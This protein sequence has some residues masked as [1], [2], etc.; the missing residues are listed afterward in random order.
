MGVTTPTT[1]TGRRPG[2]ILGTRVLRTEDPALLV[3]TAHY[4]ADVDLGDYH[5]DG[6]LHAVFVRSDVA[7]GRLIAVHTD[8]AAAMDGV[9]AIWTAADLDVNP[10]HGFVKVHDD[11]TRP[12]LATDTVRFVGE[13]IAVVLART[14]TAG[15]DA[16]EA[17]WAEIEPLPVLVD[18]EAAL[19]ADAPAIFEPHG[20]NL[21]LQ[22]VDP[23]PLDLEAISDHVVRGRY[24]NQRVAV[25]S[26]ETDG[27]AAAPGR[28]GR[29]VVWPSTQMPHVV[30]DQLAAA[31]ALE[32]DQLHIIT[33]QVGG[34]FGG[35]VG[36]HHEFSVVAAAA[37]RL[38]RPVAWVPTRRED[39]VSMPH[40]RGQ[41]QYVELGCRT[42][43]T[44]T[45][46]RVRLV[47]DAGAYPTIGAFLCG[48]TRRM[49]NATY[50]FGAIDFDVA[51]A[52]TNTT[53]VGAYRGAGRPEATALVERIVDQAATELGI[54]PIE[55]RLRN[56]IG[57]DA[58]PY[59]TIPGNVYDSGRY[60]MA[61]RRAA[62]LVDYDARRAE[63]ARRRE[64]GDRRWLGIGVAAYVEITAGGASE[65]Y[66]R[67]EVNPDGS[68]T[69]FAGTAAH[70]QGHATSF[71]M[72]VSD[73]TGIPVESITLVDGDT[74]RVP[75]GGGTG[76]SRSLQLGG[77]AVH[78]ATEVLVDAARQLAAEILE[79]DPADIE[80]DPA[81]GTIAVAGVPS[82]AMTWA[83]LAAR[84]GDE[85]TLQGEFIFDQHGATFPFGAHIAVVEVDSETG[86]V[87]L[88]QH[89][90]VD[91][92]GTVL[93]PTLVEGQQHGGLAAGIAQALYEEVRFDDDGNP[94]TSNFAEYGIASAAEFP[95]FDVHSTET[96]TPMNPLG[97]KGI[98]EAA[99]IGSTPAV[100]NAV[101]DALGHLGIRHLDL[102]CTP[103]RVWRAIDAARTGTV[104]DPWRDPPAIFAT[105][106]KPSL[107][108]DA[109]ADDE[110]EAGV[111]AAEGV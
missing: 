64:A 19:D 69:V 29:L 77:S 55:L 18:A 86:R 96:P 102:P 45:G 71:A 62:E 52:V 106:A 37:H 108:V 24:V 30:R 105:L 17:V 42:D 5:P 110:T 32:P 2:S 58:F 40:G 84:A 78:H 3:G 101:I 41:V 43:G 88:I 46:L 91:D 15:R 59:T 61:L 49:S 31:L 9:E 20:D 68:A 107:G 89:V 111:A 22:I 87:T 79:A 51:V 10:H 97:A 90:A 73:Q 8:D 47:G 93:N 103:E 7:H 25:A 4:L 14:A 60:A 76:G 53:P 98:G 82:T 56:F 66:A 23:G 1:A 57:D 92:C 11:F 100:Q 26:M 35:K 74:D 12:P 72:L 28:D 95:F 6:A 67:V 33:P 83:D 109:A 94:I 21:A 85:G 75:R 16:A 104:P 99:T 50:D 63:Q 39:M 27:C 81:T 38:G 13:P 34:G 36:L 65:E 70:G 48:G 54:D 80:I 44:F